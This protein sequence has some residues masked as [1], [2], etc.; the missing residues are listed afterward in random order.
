MRRLLYSAAVAMALLALGALVA[1]FWFAY[2]AALTPGDQDTLADAAV[3]SFFLAVLSGIGSFAAGFAA[4][5]M[6]S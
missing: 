2:S 3:L 4:S 1:M 5:E 6:T